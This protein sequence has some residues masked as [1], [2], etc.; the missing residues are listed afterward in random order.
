VRVLIAAGTPGFTGGGADELAYSL[1]RALVAAGHKA[2]ILWVPM[3]EDTVR[4]FPQ[5]VGLR[6]H[7]FSRDADHL[8]SLRWPAHYL[9]HDRKSIW[10]LHEY[11]PLF[12]LAGYVGEM[13]ALQRDDD[14][15]SGLLA[16]WELAAL[17][18]ARSTFSNSRVV[19]DRVARS[20]NGFALE[21]LEPPYPHML[22]SAPP[23]PQGHHVVLLGRVAPLKRPDLAIRALAASHGSW[24][25]TIAGV[26]SADSFGEALVLLAEQL[27]V[28]N[29][30]DF[31]LHWISEDEKAALLAR[32][33]VVLNLAYAE[34]SY[35]Y[36]T[37]EGWGAG[38]PVVTVT[39]SGGIAHAVREAGG[40]TVATSD[41]I[42]LAAAIEELL[43]HPD[44]A[45]AL[46]A[47][48]RQ[49]VD[50]RSTT[51]DRALARL[52]A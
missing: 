48:G 29:R 36:V 4:L 10:M 23:F 45:E 8:I 26:P 27:G 47:A 43:N 33:A 1:E 25:L 38:R 18:E 6:T 28:A 39:D 41:P 52:L 34:D 50:T 21:V 5:L 16:Q 31:R 13:G 11:R 30:I 17:S 7:D 15:R 51:W 42:H 44:H 49:W 37:Y 32:S 46:G 22:P 19:A 3:R 12:D 2:E 9:R 35:S 24:T 40:G 20:L 14:I